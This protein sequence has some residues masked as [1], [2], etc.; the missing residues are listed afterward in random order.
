[1]PTVEL[2]VHVRGVPAPGPL[3]CRFRSHYVGGGLVDEE[4]QLWDSSGSLVAQSR[5]LALVPRGD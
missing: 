1:V 4:G 3:R 5:Q 2:T